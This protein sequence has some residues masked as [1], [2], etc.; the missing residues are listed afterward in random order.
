MATRK[1]F[2]LTL[3]AVRLIP[4]TQ[5]DPFSIINAENAA[6]NSKSN[7]QLPVFSILR[8]QVPVVSTCPCTK[9]PSSRLPSNRLRSIF[10]AVPVSQLPMVVFKSVSS[11]AVTRYSAL[12][13]SSTVRQTPLWLMLWSTLNSLVKGQLNQNVLLEPLEM[14]SLTIPVDSIMPVNM[15][16]NYRKR[17]HDSCYGLLP[18]A[19]LPNGP[20]DSNHCLTSHYDP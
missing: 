8:V 7:S 15:G 1:L 20:S 12:R 10:T 9:W 13:I 2:L 3:K 6:G 11:M 14:T 17:G 19:V 5:I 4:F 18:A 16:A